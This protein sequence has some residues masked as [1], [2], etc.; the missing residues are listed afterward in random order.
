M[1]RVSI[2]ASRPLE[3]QL[4]V[5][6]A[7]VRAHGVVACPTDTLYALAA[8]PWSDEALARVFAIKGRPD[9]RPV[10]LMAGSIAQA[11]RAGELSARA[12]RLASRFWPGPLTL[13]VP[14]RPGLARGVR[15]EAG[16]VGIRVPDHAVAR[17]LAMACGHALTATSANVS[18]QAPTADPD[19]VA[20]SLPDLPVLVDA[21]PS[22]GGPPS[23]M[24]EVVGGA[25]RLLRGGAVSWDRVLESLGDT[26]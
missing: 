14:A 8:D 15:S 3:P 7:A 19:V 24:V 17:A 18:E 12:Q 13:V 9:D 23:T 1:I 11:E 16:L 21:G 10:A 20:R 25:V 6:A 22:P 5:A 26:P 4:A 2:D